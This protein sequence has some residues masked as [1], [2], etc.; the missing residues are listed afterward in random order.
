MRRSLGEK[1][2]ELSEGGIRLAARLYGEALDGGG[3]YHET[4]RILPASTF[5]Y[6]R[7]TVERPLRLR[8][9]A[10]EEALERLVGKKPVQKLDEADRAELFDTLREALAGQTFLS[11]DAFRNHLRTVF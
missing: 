9:A 10:D 11:R 1:R 6:R 2:R 4:S 7:I 8:F 3:E 5:G